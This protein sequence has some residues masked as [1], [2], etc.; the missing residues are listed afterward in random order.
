[1]NINIEYIENREELVFKKF[2]N[3]L[4]SEG[5]IDMIRRA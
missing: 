2:D 4:L 1:M 5:A 3:L